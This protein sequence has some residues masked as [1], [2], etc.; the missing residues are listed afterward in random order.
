[1]AKDLARSQGQM[2]QDWLKLVT[3]LNELE[4]QR[5][6]EKKRTAR[7]KKVLSAPTVPEPIDI[8][9]DYTELILGFVSGEG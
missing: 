6:A 2:N 5:L 4:Q 9:Q 8:E 1:M 7:Q 3:E